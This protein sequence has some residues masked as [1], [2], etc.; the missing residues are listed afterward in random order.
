MS[1]ATVGVCLDADAAI[2]EALPLVTKAVRAVRAKGLPHWA[3]AEEMEGEGN[4]ALCAA[5]AAGKRGAGVLYTSIHSAVVNYIQREEVRHRGQVNTED[6]AQADHSQGSTRLTSGAVVG[7]VDWQAEEDMRVKKIALHDA[8]AQLPD[9][10]RHVMTM[11][12][13]G[14]LTQADIARKTGVSQQA[15]SA[16]ISKST[17]ALKKIM[18]LG[19]KTGGAN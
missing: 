1:T 10:D 7:L 19:C 11:H 6:D 8:M 17:E 15:I 13:F 9:T 3:D 18:G 12:F 4:L 14:G 2:I 5:V 16:T